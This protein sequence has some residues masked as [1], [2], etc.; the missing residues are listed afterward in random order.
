ML[1]TPY[2][3]FSFEKTGC[4]ILQETKT[5]KLNAPADYDFQI[6]EIY[7]NWKLSRIVDLSKFKTQINENDKQNLEHYCLY[8]DRQ[9][10]GNVKE[11]MKIK[12]RRDE[13]GMNNLFVDNNSE[14]VL[15][16]Y[17]RRVV[18]PQNGSGI[19][20]TECYITTNN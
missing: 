13:M 16:G 17:I 7:N 14:N 15:V 20:T 5:P 2:F 1:S 12:W 3:L 8:L 11:G 4:V 9:F 10:V 19:G 6:I 18:N